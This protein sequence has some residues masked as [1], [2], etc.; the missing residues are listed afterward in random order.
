MDGIKVK[1]KKKFINLLFRRD[2]CKSDTYGDCKSSKESPNGRESIKSAF[3]KYHEKTLSREELEGFRNRG[4]SYLGVFGG[5]SNYS[6][7][8]DIK[9]YGEG[10]VGRPRKQKGD[11]RFCNSRKQRKKGLKISKVS[12]TDCPSDTGDGES[13]FSSFHK[14]H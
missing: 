2:I 14:I 7:A 1:E 5:I 3:A 6:K 11:I 8:I 10:K 4:F 12:A 9:R 13:I